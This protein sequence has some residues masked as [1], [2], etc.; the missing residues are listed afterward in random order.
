M[1][2]RAKRFLLIIGFL[3]SAVVI[4]YLLYAAFFRVA[5]R[6]PA[7]APEAP[8]PEIPRAGL[9]PAAPG[10]PSSGAAAEAED[11]LRAADQVARGGVTSTVELTTAPVEQTALAGDGTRVHFYDRGDGKFYRLQQDGSVE[12]LSDQA[13]PGLKKATWNRDAARAV[14]EFPDGSNIVYDFDNETQVTLPKHWED[15]DFSPVT[16]EL[17]A[18][19]MG[20]DPD[21]R[22]I[23]I[24]NDT[25][26]NVKPIQALG[27]NEAKVHINWSPNNQVVAFSDTADALG[28]FERKN[29]IP[30][31]KEQE[32]FKAL[33]VEGLGFSSSWS[34]DGKKL[35]YSVSGS[36]SNYRPLLWI[37]DATSATMGQN[38]RSLP[39]NTWV[40]KCA[41]ATASKAYCAVPQ[42]LPPNAGLQ[43]PLFADL[44]D[45]LYEVNIATGAVNLIALPETNKTMS[46]LFVTSD[47]SALYFTNTQTGNLEMIKLQ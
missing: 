32:N 20:L 26:S 24:S 2:E 9:V 36:Y 14:L 38:R 41:F 44:P 35:L 30:L 45:A 39:L 31:G 47:Q 12:T 5:P 7:P 18:K 6:A 37:V 46:N 13:F 42:G 43:P 16:D 8:A 25:G 29:I 3:L 23:V 17:V 10:T 40:E 19:S 27:E 28:S 4:A 34:P 11:G 22:W 21:N 15:F 1:D 33:T